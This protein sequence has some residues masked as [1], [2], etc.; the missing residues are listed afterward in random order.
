MSEE[1][2]LDRL[3]RQINVTKTKTGYHVEIGEKDIVFDICEGL[4][5]KIDVQPI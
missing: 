1:E 5:E 3:R 2:I 4:E